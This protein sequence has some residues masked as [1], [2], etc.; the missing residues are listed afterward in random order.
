MKKDKIGVIICCIA[1]I[2]A[3]LIIFVDKFDLPSE[4]ISEGLIAIIS[5][6]IGILITIAATGILIDSQSRVE[7]RKEKDMMQ[8]SKKQDIYHDFLNQLE[9]SVMILLS[10]CIN[11]NDSKK[12]E[13]IDT[14]GT[15]IFEFGNLRMHM[16]ETI[17]ISVINE[18][19][20]I[21]KIYREA[22]L[23][24]VYRIEI[25][26]LAREKKT[27]SIELNTRLYRLFE[28]LALHL[29]EISKIL[30]NDLYG[31]DGEDATPTL[32]EINTYISK[33]LNQCGLETPEM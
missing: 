33:F 28:S 11:G 21:F 17:F 22:S 24:Q 5:A 3:V 8:F 23:K 31:I 26:R 16:P 1:I 30:H 2:L 13:N 20:E 15:I 29:L 32:P 12:F 25:E 27:K 18:V 9:H 19:S 10:R 14:L 7:S 6:F 4:D